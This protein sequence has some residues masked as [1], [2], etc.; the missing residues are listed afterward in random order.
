MIHAA[1]KAAPRRRESIRHC[2]VFFA[3]S[4]TI[5]DL[6]MENDKRLFPTGKVDR[7]IYFGGLK[8]ALFQFYQF[9]A[10]LEIIYCNILSKEYIITMGPNIID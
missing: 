5:S 4:A 2:L 9:V 6:N 1:K 10:R 7:M 3:N 8:Y